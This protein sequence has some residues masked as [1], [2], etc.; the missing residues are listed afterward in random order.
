M[1]LVIEFDE[2]VTAYDN[3][4]EDYAKHPERY[5]DDDD[6]YSGRDYADFLVE[7]LAGYVERQD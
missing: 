4:L 3:W 6:V 7:L 1:Q 2:L 5:G